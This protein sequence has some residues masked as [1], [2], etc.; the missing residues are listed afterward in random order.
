VV[1][2]VSVFGDNNWLKSILGLYHLPLSMSMHDQIKYL[3]RAPK[4]RS[5]VD[6]IFFSTYFL[7]HLLRQIGVPSPPS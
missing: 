5:T 6:K 3:P 7:V 1:G 4:I 2:P